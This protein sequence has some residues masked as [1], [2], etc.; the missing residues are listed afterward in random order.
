MQEPNRAMLSA[1]KLS[2]CIPTKN[3]GAFIGQTLQS[4]IDQAV[5]G[6]EIVIVDG[7]SIDNTQ[8]VVKVFERKFPELRYF[9]QERAMGV[10]KDLATAVGLARGDYCWLMSADDVL[11]AGAVRRVMLE[12]SLGLDTYLC[13]RTEFDR[14][15]KPITD[16]YW[17]KKE[18]NDRVFNFSDRREIIEYFSLARSV[19]ALFSYISSIIF[20]RR[21]WKLVELDNRL[22]GSNYMHVN[23]LLTML[24]AGGKHK[25]IRQPLILCRRYNDSFLTA[26]DAGV[27]KRYLIDIDGY[28]LLGEL[29][30][31]D[32]A[33]WKAFMGVMQY[34][35]RWFML[36]RLAIRLQD[37]FEWKSI[38]LKLLDYGYNPSLIFLINHIRRIERFLPFIRFFRLIRHKL[39]AC[40]L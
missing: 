22:I 33:V 39:C 16:R 10:D 37:D 32:K 9:R 31:P 18:I 4:I 3:F 15:L 30:F 26:G 25:Y 40:F 14:N 23:T 36:I 1:I 8:E 21:K 34:E 11:K 19:G 27:V 2:I 12:I 35:H 28:H 7:G 13:N 17:L 6:L 20:S 24:K 29:L 38:E 5:D